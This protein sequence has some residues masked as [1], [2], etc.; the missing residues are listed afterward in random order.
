MSIEL[1]DF[2]TKI[3]IEIHAAL[4]AEHLVTGKDKS[5]ICRDVMVIW[6]MERIHKARLLNDALKAQG[7]SGIEAACYGPRSKI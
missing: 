3:T 5:E 2:R 4:E 6:A 1:I 7:I